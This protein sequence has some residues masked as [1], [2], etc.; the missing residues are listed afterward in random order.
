MFLV[1]KLK[2]SSN[3]AGATESSRPNQVLKNQDIITTKYK[4][5]WIFCLDFW[6]FNLDFMI[7]RLDIILDVLLRAFIML[8]YP[9][10]NYIQ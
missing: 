7:H 9:D 8:Y 2:Y 1:N 10:F 3:F 4:F 6:N 5:V